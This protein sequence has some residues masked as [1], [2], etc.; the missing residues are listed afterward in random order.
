M[1]NWDITQKWSKTSEATTIFKNI[2]SD[3][4]YIKTE[5]EQ[6]ENDSQIL[7][8]EISNCKTKI[9]EINEDNEKIILNFLSQNQ[10]YIDEIT[11]YIKF[12]LS[13]ET[14]YVQII[15]WLNDVAVNKNIVDIS[16]ELSKK[17]FSEKWYN[18]FSVVQSIISGSATAMWLNSNCTRPVI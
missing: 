16:S 9:L 12:I 7:N 5:W 15:N 17:T 10:S 8:K 14:K 2:D 3:S 11:K 6:L 4:T 18:I 1:D 13:L